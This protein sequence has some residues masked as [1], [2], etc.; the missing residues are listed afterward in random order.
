ML[1][2]QRRKNYLVTEEGTT[3]TDVEVAVTVD[4]VVENVLLN[5]LLMVK[6]KKAGSHQP[7]AAITSR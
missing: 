6:L 3:V 1:I 5:G 4:V 7:V 2:N